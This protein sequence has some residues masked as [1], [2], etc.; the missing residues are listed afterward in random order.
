[1]RP[2]IK[3][4]KD[5]IRGSSI[6]KS[7]IMLCLW[8][9][10]N[11]ADLYK[12]ALLP[13]LHIFFPICVAL[14][15]LPLCHWCTSC[16]T[17]QHRIVHHGGWARTPVK[18]PTLKQN[19]TLLLGQNSAWIIISL[20]SLLNQN[21]EWKPQNIL[22]ASSE[23][24]LIGT[25]WL[26]A[27]DTIQCWNCLHPV[28]RS[29]SDLVSYSSSSLPSSL[30]LSGHVTPT[31]VK[32]ALSFAPY[33]NA[34]WCCPANSFTVWI[35]RDRFLLKTSYCWWEGTVLTFASSS[36]PATCALL[37]LLDPSDL[38]S[39]YQCIKICMFCGCVFK[40]G[41]RPLLV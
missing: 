13:H 15:L 14:V 25:F 1:M 19:L 38:P 40:S 39:M 3:A 2:E 9:T 33:D 16:G 41:Q 35:S 24:Q 11:Y 5:V 28:K 7:S 6:Q 37:L 34:G 4:V 22:L 18:E 23:Q 21:L 20:K 31:S 36:P 17:W 12:S 29:P 32:Q 27:L 30:F 10:T 8:Y 26:P